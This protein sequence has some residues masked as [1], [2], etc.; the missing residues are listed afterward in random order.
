MWFVKHLFQ[1][2]VTIPHFHQKYFLCIT[3]NYTVCILCI[4]SICFIR[5]HYGNLRIY[6]KSTP[7]AYCI[8]Q[9]PQGTFLIWLKNCCSVKYAQNKIRIPSYTKMHYGILVHHL[10]LPAIETGDLLDSVKCFHSWI[11]CACAKFFL[12]AQKLVVFGN[13]LGSAWG[14]CLNL[15]GVQC[16]CKI[17]NRCICCFTGTM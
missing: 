12:N 15:A 1:K 7:N 14:T 2:Y 5:Y 8:S 6:A 11:Y 16:Y 4:M 3:H 17:S 9:P 10:L 13:T